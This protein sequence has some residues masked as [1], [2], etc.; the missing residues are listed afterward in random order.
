MTD[1]NQAP[2]LSQ[3]RKA[4]CFYEQ[5]PNLFTSR[6]SF[7]KKLERRHSNGLIASGAVI[8][9]ALGLLVDPLRFSSWLLHPMQYRRM[10]HGIQ[11]RAA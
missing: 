9:S 2:D 7:R 4:Y 11:G 1:A 10:S 5:N 3:L 6:E 8:E